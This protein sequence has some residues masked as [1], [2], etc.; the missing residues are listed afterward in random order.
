MGLI[1]AAV[2]SEFQT[3]IMQCLAFKGYLHV[4]TEVE[5]S[6][7]MVDIRV[8]TFIIVETPVKSH[9]IS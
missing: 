3:S 9:Q 6:N 4:H 7:K 5:D 1:T 2:M 8:T